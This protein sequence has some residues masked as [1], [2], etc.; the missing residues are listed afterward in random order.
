MTFHDK[1]IRTW[2]T[3]D[4][5]SWLRTIPLDES[6]ISEITEEQIDGEVLLILQ[7][8]GFCDLN[9]PQGPKIKIKKRFRDLCKEKEDANKVADTVH[10][11]TTQPDIA[12]KGLE[13]DTLYSK[14]DPFDYRFLDINLKTS[15]DQ[16]KFAKE[17]VK[18]VCAS[19]NTK[20]LTKVVNG[21]DQSG[22]VT[23]ICFQENLPEFLRDQ[24]K[25]GF[26]EQQDTV[27]QCVSDPDLL[28][29]KL[30]GIPTDKYI[31][32]VTVTPKEDRC[33]GSIF[34]V[35][36]PKPGGKKGKKTPYMYHKNQLAIMKREELSKLQESLE[37]G[38]GQGQSESAEMTGPK[39][40]K[41]STS[42]ID[43][44]SS[45][46]IRD[47]CMPLTEEKTIQ[48]NNGGMANLK[49]LQS[50]TVLDEEDVV[51]EI[52]P[53]LFLSAFDNNLSPKEKES[54]PC[55]GE[56]P[57]KAVFDFDA[58]AVMYKATEQKESQLIRVVPDVEI[59][60][61]KLRVNVE[62]PTQLNDIYSEIEQS[63]KDHLKHEY[64]GPMWIFSNGYAI[65][66]KERVDVKKWKK[67]KHTGMR[68][69]IKY[70]DDRIPMR[71]TLAVI[72]IL[73]EETDVFV[74]A[75]AEV[76]SVFGDQWV[77]LGK[78]EYFPKVLKE[79]E[80][81]NCMDEE[82]IK[83]RVIPNLSFSDICSAFTHII[84]ISNDE[85]CKIPFKPN[86]QTST[87]EISSKDLRHL[88]DIDILS[89]NKC[90][91]FFAQV[92]TEKQKVLL[93]Q[94]ELKYYNG[95]E[96][97]W[98][99][100]KAGK[101]VFERDIV[102]TLQEKVVN[103]VT[104]DVI[105]ERPVGKVMLYHHPGAGG[106]TAAKN[107]L[108]NLRKL[109]RCVVLKNIT[110]ETSKQ[111]ER[112]W[113]EGYEDIHCQP[114][115][116]IVL[117][118]NIE[119]DTLD[120]LLTEME[121]KA[122]QLMRPVVNHEKLPSVFVFLV[123]VR[124]T[125]LPPFDKSNHKCV[126]G[127]SLSPKELDWWRRTFDRLE[128]RWRDKTIP[129]NRRVDPKLLISF[130]IMK[131]GFNKEEIKKITER[132]VRN[133]S[134]EIER[135]LLGFLAIINAFDTNFR[136]IPAS[137]FDC[138]MEDY[139]RGYRKSSKGPMRQEHI[140]I[141][142][143]GPSGIFLNQKNQDVAWISKLS[144]EF[145]ILLND[146]A[147]FHR[148]STTNLRL[149]H[150]LLSME[151]LY[152]LQDLGH[153]QTT[154]GE[155]VLQFLHC[156]KV[157]NKFRWTG[158]ITRNIV[159]T[160][161][162]L[163]TKREHDPWKRTK[164][165]F[166]P[167][168]QY[169]TANENS[170]ICF[171][172]IRQVFDLS[173]DPF[174][175][176]LLARLSIF[177][178]NWSQAEQYASEATQLM[179]HNSALW[180][181]YGRIYKEKLYEKKKTSQGSNDELPDMIMIASAGIKLFQKSQQCSKKERYGFVNNAGYQG[182]LE[183]SCLLLHYLAKVECF[184]TPGVLARAVNERDYLPPELGTQEEEWRESIDALKQLRPN[185]ELAL[186]TLEDE[187]LHLKDKKI[188]SE[189][190]TK[191][192]EN[193]F[194]RLQEIKAN[195]YSYLKED[196]TELDQ[197]P[198]IEKCHIRRLQIKNRGGNSFGSILRLAET[199]SGFETLLKLH[200]MCEQNVSSR[201][202]TPHDYKM[203]L[204]LTLTLLQNDRVISTEYAHLVDWS[205]KLYN[206]REILLNIDRKVHLEPYLFHAMLIW[207]R[208]SNKCCFLAQREMQ[209]VLVN[210]KK[211]FYER[212]PRQQHTDRQTYR[213]DVQTIFFLSNG[214]GTK[215]IIS[216]RY[217]RSKAEA[218]GDGFWWHSIVIENLQRFT[219]YAKQVD[220]I[221][222]WLEDCKGNKG[223]I[224]IPTSLP[225]RRKDMLHKQVYFAIG[226]TWM[227]PKA[228]D[229]AL[230][231]YP[232]GPAVSQGGVVPH[233]KSNPPPKKHIPE[234][235]TLRSLEARIDDIIGKLE[236]LKQK[237]KDKEVTLEEVV[238]NY[239]LI[240]LCCCF[241]QNLK[242]LI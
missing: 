150:P 182:E 46:N 144:T 61:T 92:D 170:E 188:I 174:V 27:L 68:N 148:R 207:P 213:K 64:P 175:A 54:L 239:Q 33:M 97:S 9:V 75:V 234:V 17:F 217:L 209:D 147:P 149:V 159:R 89:A 41:S 63:L 4:V 100:F 110:K 157:F 203:M 98:L 158:I 16:L 224:C 132:F 133:I 99:N 29:V 140:C 11:S 228:Y 66:G 169:L 12:S 24:L 25:R 168:I 80:R 1:D 237:Q 232:H 225:I 49:R 151:V 7:E 14:I 34:Y 135:K 185:I 108:W 180:D 197:M 111:I 115:P 193:Q 112:V 200:R 195:I 32:E 102:K 122:K 127:Q 10:P 125:D 194:E 86:G 155:M 172:I 171:S 114:K 77:V 126:L 95:A 78:E 210:W 37:Q 186:E 21:V 223:N 152:V 20:Q 71:H 73:S 121:D 178:K 221:E 215:S 90:E 60:D 79:L 184:K 8:D 57:W 123:C 2:T 212:Y 142:S 31:F 201:H 202:A 189:A 162:D 139:A 44:S 124:K 206:R 176:Q 43:V 181:T 48:A 72:M 183:I 70:F 154:I 196:V 198:E 56:I 146:P 130:N 59:F 153:M 238:I 106:T 192:N 81:R 6:A 173:E 42:N 129:G 222:V 116:V 74:E 55:I 117:A 94:E 164:V 226:F 214:E 38:K 166:S 240:S 145:R 241:S 227:G 53:I 107:V 93:D 118:D 131:S 50:L 205:R 191:E 163:V 165:R 30:G 242:V 230:E 51:G 220:E 208:H 62:D 190:H 236:K 199:D 83:E 76:I 13:K 65:G 128:E 91:R 136:V 109:Y 45:D 216:G 103:A 22:S 52:Y 211:A 160:M 5:E 179:P 161:V 18:H 58:N 235:K 87:I 26:F 23:G 15:E 229:V 167:L 120:L 101:H 104:P 47:D 84:G 137:T 39:I 218:K 19:L 143:A 36:V 105:E 28:R 82:M 134:S 187:R 204:E 113:K 40:Q 96:V 35:K 69:A 67:L 119:A 3:E 219:G 141:F 156:N 85:S 138:F 231:E 233:A 177:Y 88:K